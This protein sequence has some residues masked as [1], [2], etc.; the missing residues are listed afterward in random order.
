MSHFDMLSMFCCELNVVPFVVHKELWLK[1]LMLAMK[2]PL[3]TTVL[4][5][6]TLSR[7]I[8]H[9][10]QQVWWVVSKKNTGSHCK[11]AQCEMLQL[12]EIQSNII[13]SVAASTQTRCLFGIFSLNHC[14][15]VFI[16]MNAAE[17]LRWS[18][19]T[20][21]KPTAGFESGSVETSGWR[22]DG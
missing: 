10:N 1:A 14:K 11:W 18:H 6:F 5:L 12:N 4:F 2:Q 15:A 21:Y 9:V 17:G 7:I 13:M 16:Q 22:D 19:L 20:L 8:W 3:L